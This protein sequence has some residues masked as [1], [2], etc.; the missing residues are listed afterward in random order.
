MNQAD[1]RVAV[2]IITHN[3]RDE[4]LTS[5]AHLTRLPEKPPIVLVDNASVDGTSE[6]VAE[7][8]PSVEVVAAGSNLGA[9]ARNLG[10]QRV[11]TPYVA[12]C[13]DDT[14]WEPGALRC[15][16]NLFEANPRLAVATARIVVGPEQEE[17]PICAELD[18]SPLPRQAGMPGPSLLGF[19]AGASVVRRDA[20]LDVGGFEPRFFIGGEEELLALDLVAAGWWL[21]YTPQLLVH[22]HPSVRRDGVSRRW[23]L[24]RNALWSAWLRR[25][26]LAALWKSGRILRSASSKREAWR[27]MTAAWAGL[28]WVLRHRRV[29]PPHVEQWLG[30][31]EKPPLSFSI[32]R[33]TE[34]CSSTT[35]SRATACRAAPSV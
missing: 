15:A 5:L 33:T 34:L 35:T 6:A 10:V 24:V 8:F 7:R 1:D 13:D 11:Q 32:P 14:W 3:R 26:L 23:L 9:A 17:D 28:P 16:A 29:V 25:P 30:L 21:C 18:R 4:V 19:M 2:V 27:G 12:L 31:L 20:F 22:H